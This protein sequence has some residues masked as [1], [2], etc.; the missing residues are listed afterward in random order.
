MVDDKSN[1][2]VVMPVVNNNVVISSAIVFQVEYEDIESLTWSVIVNDLE[3]GR[4]SGS[5]VVM[6]GVSRRMKEMS[7]VV[8]GYNIRIIKWKG[9][10]HER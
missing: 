1:T 6:I 3:V 8:N 2:S 9:E 10:T 7:I 4:G 5:L